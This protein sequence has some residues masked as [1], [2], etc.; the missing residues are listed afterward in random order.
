MIE[1][2]TYMIETINLECTSA[3]HFAQIDHFC[4]RCDH[5][6]GG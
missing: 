2:V 4:D 1:S 6:R 5:P 3:A